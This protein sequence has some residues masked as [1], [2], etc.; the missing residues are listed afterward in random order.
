MA[1]LPGNDNESRPFRSFTIHHNT[2]ILLNCSLAV[3]AV[4]ESGGVH[5]AEGGGGMVAT[6]DNQTK[7]CGVIIKWLKHLNTIFVQS[8]S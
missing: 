3:C 2:L 8:P 4:L 7:V 5:D 1:V 6:F